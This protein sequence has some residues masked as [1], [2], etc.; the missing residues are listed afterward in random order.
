MMMFQ[1]YGVKMISGEKER[2]HYGGCETEAEASDAIDLVLL[3]CDYAYA[4]HPGGATM[5]Y[6]ETTDHRYPSEPLQAKD[7]HRQFP[8]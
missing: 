4:K 8:G 3:Q 7:V 1:I 5:I 6:R 2:R